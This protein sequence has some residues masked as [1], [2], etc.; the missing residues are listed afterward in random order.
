MDL[1]ISKTSKQAVISNK[2]KLLEHT[3]YAREKRFDPKTFQLKTSGNSA[4]Q[5]R[6]MDL[7]FGHITLKPVK[8]IQA[9]NMPYDIAIGKNSNELVVAQKTDTNCITIIEHR[10][11]RRSLSGKKKVHLK[12]KNLCALAV[13]PDGQYV[14]VCTQNKVEKL[15]IRGEQLFPVAGYDKIKEPHGIAVDETT[16]K[17]F[18]VNGNGKSILV[19]PENIT[20]ELQPSVDSPRDLAFD[21]EGNLYIL[22]R[23]CIKRFTQQGV[24]ISQFGT[25]PGGSDSEP[26]QLKMAFSITRDENGLVYVTE[27]I[28]H[29][30][31]VFNEEGRFLCCFGG[32]G[33]EEGQ[34]KFPNGIMAD[35][36]GQLY[37]CD[38]SNNRIVVFDIL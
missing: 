35:G 2:S 23:N 19:L 10:G 13:S 32:Y 9:V 37:V 29:C 27:E 20:Y 36:N 3:K 34:F 16:G 18:V 38:R 8:I 31:S 15:Q 33:T 1:N 24:F 26:A 28:S 12:F 17:V 11:R 22:E 6:K 14:W 25:K 21:R 30:V 7:A 4:F 5:S